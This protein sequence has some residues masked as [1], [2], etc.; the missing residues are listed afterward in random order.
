M[1]DDALTLDVSALP[2]YAFSHRSLMWWGTL[3]IMLI[4]GTMFLVLIGAYFYLRGRVPQWPPN[5]APPEWRY[6][7]A[8]TIVLLLSIL[9]NIWYKRAAERLDLVKVRI[10]LLIAIAFAVVFTVLRFY[11]FGTLNCRYDTNAYG[12]VVWTLLGLHT[13]HLITDLI[14]TIVVTALMFTDKLEGKRFVDISE[15]AFYWYFVV[16]AW[17][18]IFVVLYVVP[19]WI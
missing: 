8:N 7:V 2:G 15:N 9:P 19:R 14:D 13:T 4:E 3:G 5:L 18:P 10:G 6:G 11:E 16:L 12:S 17:V 1:N